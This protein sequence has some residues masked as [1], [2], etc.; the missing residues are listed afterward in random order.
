MK[1]YLKVIKQYADFGGRARRKEL[2]YFVLFN[3]IFAI[4]AVIIDTVAGWE[5]AA[6][7]YGPCYGAY[8]GVMLLP[9]LAV[10]VRR[11]HDLGKSGWWLLIGLIPIVG[12]IWLLVLYCT[13]GQSEQNRYGANPKTVQQQYFPGH[14]REKSIAIAFIVG[15]TTSLIYSA[16]NWIQ[17]NFFTNMPLLFWMIPTLIIVL[18]L[19]F[20]VFYFPAGDSHKTA[21]RQNTAFVLLAISMLISAIW[22]IRFLIRSHMPGLILAGNIVALLEHLALLALTVLLL[23]KSERKR[24]VPVAVLTILFTVINII[25][26]LIQAFTLHFINPFAL[27]LSVAVILLAVHCLQG[28]AV[29]TEE[30][31]SFVSPEPSHIKIAVSNKA[32]ENLL[33]EDFEKPID[34]ELLDRWKKYVAEQKNVGIT[35]IVLWGVGLFLLI[36]LGGIIGLGVFFT[37]FITAMVISLS[38]RKKVKESFNRL[39]ITKAELKQAINVSNNRIKL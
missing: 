11:L 18:M 29:A 4:V 36:L 25:I 30:E 34:K 3:F 7:N 38:S 1:W 8:M 5:V 6:N 9:A 27:I 37:L 32:T 21:N 23:L 31:I 33:P 20:G 24:M 39:G 13:D 19:L 2:W 28:K 26:Q 22:G 15:A 17:H 12:G 16:S 14:R 10:G 35:V